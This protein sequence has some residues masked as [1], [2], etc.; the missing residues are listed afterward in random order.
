MVWA[1]LDASSKVSPW[2]T[3]RAVTPPSRCA[4][5]H[6]ET[7][8]QRGI[9]RTAGIPA[10]FAARATPRAWFPALAAI[11]PWTRVRSRESTLLAAP[12]IL[13]DPEYCRFSS[14]ERIL[15]P[16]REERG[17]SSTRGVAYAI[18]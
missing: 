4:A 14:L 1:C 18:W 10:S 3:M 6:L 13:N 17:V 2:L 9:T 12:R 15:P 5:A 11:T 7:G 8:D 16:N